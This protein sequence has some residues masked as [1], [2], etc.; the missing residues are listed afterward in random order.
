MSVHSY[1]E[2]T[3]NLAFHSS[4]VR[5][6]SNEMLGL[7]TRIAFSK[8]LYEMGRTFTIGEEKECQERSQAQTEHHTFVEVCLQVET[9]SFYIPFLLRC[10]SEYCNPYLNNRNVRNVDNNN[11]H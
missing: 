5:S 3:P 2:E 7:T 8:S 6:S 1:A 9:K 4:R 11:L 10:S